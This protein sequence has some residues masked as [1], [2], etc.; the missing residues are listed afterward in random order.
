VKLRA[1]VISVVADGVRDAT[2]V[3]HVLPLGGSS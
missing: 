2:F 1:P 3:T